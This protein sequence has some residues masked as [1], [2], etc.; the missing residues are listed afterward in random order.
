MAHQLEGEEA[1]LERRVPPVFTVGG[2]CFIKTSEDFEGGPV[3]LYLVDVHSFIISSCPSLAAPER[4]SSSSTRRAH[5]TRASVHLKFM[6][7]LPNVQ[8]CHISS[9][10]H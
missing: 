6:Y 8:T 1:F 5:P 4:F 10:R 2:V 9:P 3:E 7:Y